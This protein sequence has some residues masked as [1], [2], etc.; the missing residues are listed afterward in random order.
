MKESF[1]NNRI[2]R[3]IAVIGLSVLTPIIMTII[4][5]IATENRIEGMKLA[6]HPGVFLVHIFLGYFFVRKKIIE[7]LLVTIALSTLIYWTVLYMATNDIIVKTG[8]D[9]YGFWDLALL[10]LMVGLV[11]WETYLHLDNR[12]IANKEK[13]KR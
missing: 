12:I 9:Y 5:I 11:V 13:T 6:V 2:F 7:K 3:I 1:A 8:L 4:L 10:N